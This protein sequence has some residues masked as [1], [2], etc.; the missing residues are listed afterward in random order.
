M[1]SM[2]KK[3]LEALWLKELNKLILAHLLD[4]YLTNAILASKLSISNRMLYRKILKLI[5]QSPNHYIR[6]IRL[7]KAHKLLQSG[8]HFLS[9]PDL[10]ANILPFLPLLRI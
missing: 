10:S 4:S 8:R 9:P 2:N 6:R 5:K 7:T 1:E 3:R